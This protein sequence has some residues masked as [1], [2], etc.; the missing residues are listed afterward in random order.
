MHQTRAVIFVNGDLP[1]PAA[2]ARLIREDDFLIAADGG[3][4]HAQTMG[5][6]PDL[7]IGD[8]D[9]VSPEDVAELRA[10]NVPVQQFPPAKDET[11]IELALMTALDAG[12]QHIILLGALGGRIDHTLGNLSLLTNTALRDA[13]VRLDDGLIE[14]F[15]IWQTGVVWGQAGDLVSLLPVD[16]VVQGVTTEGLEYALRNETLRRHQGR[17]ISNVLLDEIAKITITDGMLFCIHTRQG[18]GNDN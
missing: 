2:A 9:S 10:R 6:V 17:G 15:I 11:D 12:Y 8:L 13:D 5:F 18:N 14:A 16:A 3:L 4:R 1:D 7:L